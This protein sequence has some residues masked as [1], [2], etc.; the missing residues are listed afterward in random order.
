MNDIIDT[1]REAG[2]P[3]P[4]PHT[5][6]LKTPEQKLADQKAA[7]ERA[8]RLAA[9]GGKVVNSIDGMSVGQNSVAGNVAAA[10]APDVRPVMPTPQPEVVADTSVQSATAPEPGNSVFKL[11]ADQV[12]QKQPEVSTQEAIPSDHVDDGSMVKTEKP[13]KKHWWQFSKK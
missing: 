4:S 3:A 11:P 6:D 8:A 1:T 9:Q 12:E 13:K 10:P 5:I 7:E 2:A